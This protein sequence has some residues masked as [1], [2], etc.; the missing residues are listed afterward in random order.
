MAKPRVFISSTYYDL[1]HVR[2]SLELFIDNMGY[3]S[4]LFENGDIPFDHEKSLEQS[5]YD[6]LDNCQIFVLIIGGRYG[7]PASSEDAQSDQS[8][9]DYF[10]SI[11]S[12]E[13]Q[14][15][16]K[17]EIPIYIFVEKS[18]YA[19]YRTYKENIGNESIKYAH[20]DNVNIFKLLEKIYNE[21]RN[22][23]VREFENVNDIVSW[24]RDQFAGIFY[25]LLTK[26]SSDSSINSLVNQITNLDIVVSSLKEY[27]ERIIGEIFPVG[28]SENIINTIC[29]KEKKK[30]NTQLFFHNEFMNHLIRYHNQEQ[31]ELEE[32]FSSS[33][34]MEDFFNSLEKNIDCSML[35]EHKSDLR[36]YLAKLRNEMGLPKWEIPSTG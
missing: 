13:Y 6:E 15:A 27:S 34:S 10:N 20:V 3:E 28:D 12:K 5:C 22:N 18:V 30:I 11:T 17:R 26:K 8:K 9:Y 16:Q 21:K 4:V 23:L 24:L 33:A 36:T 1:K 32:T 35:K 19:E 14:T 31:N 2:K 7:S 25:N 29:E